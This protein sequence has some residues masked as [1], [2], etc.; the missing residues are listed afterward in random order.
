MPQIVTLALVTED[1]K[2]RVAQVNPKLIGAD[3]VVH[4]GPEIRVVFATVVIVGLLYDE[5]VRPDD[6]GTLSSLARVGREQELPSRA[7][8]RR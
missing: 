8:R 3:R 2:N 7:G 6:Q 4:T 1:V 5:L